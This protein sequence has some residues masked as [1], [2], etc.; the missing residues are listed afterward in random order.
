MAIALISGA[1]GFHDFGESSNLRLLDYTHNW[2]HWQA[3]HPIYVVAIDEKS[4]RQLGPWPWKRQTHAKLLTKLKAHAP[5]NIILDILFSEA[6]TEDQASDLKLAKAI[7]NT[8]ELALP[9]HFANDS[10]HQ[11]AMEVPPAAIFYNQN[12]TLGHVHLGCNTDAICRSVYLKEGVGS[13]H[14]PHITLA[15]I[16]DELT[17]IPGM[18]SPTKEFSPYNI[19]RDYH[20]FIP[21]PNTF[22][23]IPT[24]SYVDFLNG[25]IPLGTLKN[26]TVIIGMT[27]TGFDTVA[28]P[29]GS[30]PGV[31]VN[32]IILNALQ[33]K[34]L[35]ST[36]HKL[37]VAATLSALLFISLLF[38]QKL[39]PLPFL[40]TTLFFVGALI[41]AH[42][43]IA[44]TTH[45]HIPVAVYVLALLCHYPVWSWLRLHYAYRH[46]RIDISKL[47]D[48]ISKQSTM[49]T[50]DTHPPIKGLPN[51][52]TDF[53]KLAQIKKSVN[54]QR[55]LIT[56]TLN[57]VPDA[58]IVTE[59]FSHILLHN[60]SA[61]SLLQSTDHQTVQN[62]RELFANTPA[63]TRWNNWLNSPDAP[64]ELTTQN[65]TNLLCSYTSITNA[66]QKPL[67]I[68]HLGDVTQLKKAEQDRLDTLHFL[69]HDL[70]APLTSILAVLESIPAGLTSPLDSELQRIKHY[71]LKNLE[72]SE[73]MLQLGKAESINTA[74]FTLFDGHSVLDNIYTDAL[75]SAKLKNMQVLFHASDEECWVLGNQALI[76]RALFNLISNAI[77]YCPINAHVKVSLQVTETKVEYSVKD[78]GPGIRAEERAYLF[79]R[80]KQG[81]NR[82]QLGAGLGLYFVQTVALSHEGQIQLTCPDNGGCLFTLSLPR[83]R[84]LLP[85]A[86][87]Q[88]A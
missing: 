13:P 81:S 9:I 22:S 50:E 86:D 39:N 23:V 4:I 56:K 49:V 18:R 51:L 87:E 41:S 65:K 44:L 21:F 47:D 10:L 74:G 45:T 36:T 68:F 79:E 88:T 43:V 24:L 42:Q 28:T 64:L 33:S 35:I 58:I 60:Q 78:N 8:P 61:R 12:P 52:E 76:E 38:L 54:K 46:L 3:Q 37:P 16:S 20:N 2:R 66:E 31:Y 67:Q 84:P 26:S 25:D 82:H 80:Y 59:G 69:S 27:A 48:E 19:A 70:R 63:H 40:V 62:I 7:G 15:A 1:L 77:K 14:W 30:M 29:S 85:Q 75:D 53:Q 57:Q 83:T 11:S 55:L 73:S 34:A 71:A 17:Q 6:S 5:N 72:L 32:A